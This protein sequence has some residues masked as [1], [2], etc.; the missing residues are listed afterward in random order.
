MVARH[1]GDRSTF[2]SMVSA[3][4]P[5]ESAEQLDLVHRRLAFR[6]QRHILGVQAK[7][8]LKLVA[9]QPSDDPTML[10]GF[11][12][13]GFVGLRQLR[14]SAPLI[15]AYSGARKDD[16]SLVRLHREPIEPVSGE[17]GLALL[18]DFCSKPLPELRAV[19]T[20]H[21]FVNGEILSKDVGNRAAVT[22]MAGHITRQALHRYRTEG[23]SVS[24]NVVTVRTP[25]EVLIL[26]LALRED[27]FGRIEPTMFV[28]TEHTGEM[29]WGR[30][31]S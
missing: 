18:R 28:H 3:L 29:L 22:C 4:V 19:E 6:G 26:D 5:D 12:V 13:E 27:T 7:T 21:G 9:I 2:D 20:Q 30:S 14:E 11:R 10:D 15:I 17:H 25:C 1:A 16:G 23:D 24:G 31:H 8:Q